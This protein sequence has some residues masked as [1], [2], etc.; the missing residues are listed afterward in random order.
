MIKW[1]PY[2]KIKCVKICLKVSQNCKILSTKNS[3]FELLK[4]NF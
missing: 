2:L 1:V 4:K 3:S